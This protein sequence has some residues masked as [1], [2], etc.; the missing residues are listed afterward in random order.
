MNGSKT[1][2]SA[3]CTTR[4]PA[5][6]APNKYETTTAL[7]IFTS[8]R[9]SASPFARESA[10]VPTSLVSVVRSEEGAREQRPEQVRD[11]DRALDLHVLEAQCIAVCQG[12]GNRPDELGE[13]RRE[14]D[15]G[16]AD[17]LSDHSLNSHCHGQQ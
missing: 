9:P 2:A 6:N 16:Q 14:H 7:W 8:L 3:L 17:R 10:I 1:T 15:G 12:I 4:A 5:S 11:D 13:R